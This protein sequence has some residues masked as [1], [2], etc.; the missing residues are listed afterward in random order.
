MACFMRKFLPATVAI[1]CALWAT[2]ASPAAD[3]LDQA[4]L[5]QAQQVHKVLLEKGYKNVGVLKFRV[6]KGNEPVSDNVGTLNMTL[7]NKLEIALVLANPPDESRQIGIIQNASSVAARVK[8]A[9][10]LLKEGRGPLFEETYPLA[11]G[12]QQVKPDAFLMG[13][14]RVSPDLQEM[15]VNVLAFDKVNDPVQ[16]VPP[17]TVATNANLMTEMNESFMLRG[18]FD[19]PEAKVNEQAVATA[20]DVAKK[21]A[22][23]PLQSSTAPVTLEIRYDGQLVSYDLRNGRAFVR[24]PEQ[25]QKV[26]FVL[27]R[28]AGGN[29]RY[30][31][32]LKIN[33][34]NVLFNERQADPLCHKIVLGPGAKPI[35]IRG[36]HT[37]DKTIRT[38]KVLSRLE[39]KQSEIHYSP[40][41]G[42]ISM[43]VYPERTA[44]S[45]SVN[46]SDEGEDIVAIMRGTYPEKRP[47]NLD[48]LKGQL[49]SQAA[50]D[51]RG[52]LSEGNL[53]AGNVKQT[54]FK[55]HTVPIMASTIVY[56]RP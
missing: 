43:V 28:K 46:Y 7:A 34:E 21:K 12:D 18:V 54:D 19:Q 22:D 37:T 8:R 48:A 5:K 14:A 27:R 20:A 35:T 24:E 16:V 30:G 26:E 29:E 52:I 25:G 51:L 40:D 45:K 23:Y 9:N 47:A 44:A 32:V 10:H 41:V 2:T 11:W 55:A 36:F 31:V 49:R 56:Y 39:S 13:A 1:A 15:T 50:N 33:G 38:F 6:K 3:D 53:A 42:V 17:F 4:M